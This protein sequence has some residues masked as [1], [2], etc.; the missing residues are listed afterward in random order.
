MTEAVDR[1]LAVPYPRAIEVEALLQAVT[2][3][4]RAGILTD[5]EFEAKH[6]RLVAQL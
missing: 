5:T 1:P 4:H 6:L 3:L 2:A